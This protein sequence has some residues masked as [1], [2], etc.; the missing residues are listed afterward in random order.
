M[1]NRKNNGSVFVYF[2]LI[3]CFIIIV[4]VATGFAI[5][6]NRQ[7]DVVDEFENGGNVVLNYTNNVSELRIDNMIPTTDSVG[8]QSLEDGS[9]YDFSVDVALDNATA[10]EYEITAIKDKKYSNISDDDIHI[11]LEQEKSGTFTKVFGP[12]PFTPLKSNSELGS[13]TG[14]MVLFKT[15]KTKSSVDNYRLR[16]W[17]SDKSVLTSGSFSITIK[18]N[19]L[20]K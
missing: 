3:V 19:A 9:Y 8:I 14:E 10:I 12:E 5:F 20:A 2:L 1:E 7:V 18:V 13:K 15:E 17:L 4:F 11:Y 6:S 16:M